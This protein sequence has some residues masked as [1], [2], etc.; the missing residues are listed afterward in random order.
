MCFFGPLRVNIHPAPSSF[1]GLTAKLRSPLAS[2]DSPIGRWSF[3]MVLRMQLWPT[4]SSNHHRP[5]C[6]GDMNQKSPYVWRFECHEY[7]EFENRPFDHQ[8]TRFFQ[9]PR[10]T[11]TFHRESAHADQRLSSWAAVVSHLDGKF[12]W[13]ISWTMG[14]IMGI[15]WEYH[16]K[17]HGIL[18]TIMIPWGNMEI[19]GNTTKYR[20]IPPA[21]M[22]KRCNFLGISN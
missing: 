4:A 8:P 16:G 7:H 15:S 3:L 20:E 17:Y 14:T 21:D 9:L 5:K 19:H 11:G 2:A 12:S 10:R 13:E 22:I 18:G 1:D 6:S